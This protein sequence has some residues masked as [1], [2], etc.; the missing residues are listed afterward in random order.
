M[1]DLDPYGGSDPLG[2]F[3]LFF[4]RT[5]SFA[6][7]RPMSPLFQRVHRP[8]L[9]PTND[10]FPSHR[11]CLRCLSARCRFAS[12]DLWNAVVCF[13]LIGKV[14]VSVL[15]FCVCR[16]HCKVHYIVDRKLRSSRLISVQPLVGSTI[17]E[18]C[19]RSVLWILEV[20]CCLY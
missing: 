10:R 16:I 2:M 12:D 17:R 13:L 8:P 6:G 18:F 1:L 9:L 15:H 3:P 14:W 20:L 19:I 4:N 7:D 11:Y 5:A